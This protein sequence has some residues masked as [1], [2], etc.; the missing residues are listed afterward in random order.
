MTTWTHDALAADLLDARHLA[1]EIACER[2]ML[3][4]GYSRNGQAD[5]AAMRL[6][7]TRPLTT[8]YEVKV[9][10]QD[11]LA[12]LREE[13]WRRYLAVASRVVFA[14]PRGLAQAEELPHAVGV[15][16]RGARQWRT[17]RH[18][19]AIRPEHGLAFVTALLFRHY[20]APWQGAA[21]IARL[22][23]PA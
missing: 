17:L 4:A 20:P 19:P 14:F 15:I 3:G 5:V 9:T 10:R 18:V 8:V 13:K 23:R 2:L 6:S 7:W 16:V 11:L 21:R 12:D 22:A 1:G